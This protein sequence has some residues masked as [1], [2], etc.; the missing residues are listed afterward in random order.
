MFGGKVTIC[1]LSHGDQ[2][3]FFT[4]CLDNILNTVPERRREIRVALNQPTVRLAA[5]ANAYRPLIKL[6]SAAPGDPLDPGSR[7]KYPAMRDLLYDENYPITTKYIVWFDDDSYPIDKK[8][9]VRLAEVVI[10]N[11]REGARLFGKKC[12][13]DLQL[14]NKPGHNPRTWFEQAAW[15]RNNPLQL[16]GQDRVGP[17]GSCINFVAGWFW[18]ASYEALVAAGVPDKRL[19]HNGGDITI[20]AQM[21][22]AGFKIKDFNPTKQFVYTPPKAEGGRR[23]F[24]EAFPWADPATRAKHVMGT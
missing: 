3:E 21:Y 14:Y 18:A 13:H 4:R 22:Q 10:P 11:H 7:K 8:W 19:R 6:L 23:S 15:W 5:A 16:R 12:F 20:G 17:N 24:S 9:L 1:I 2:V